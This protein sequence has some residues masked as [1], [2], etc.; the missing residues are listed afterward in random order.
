MVHQG[1]N[2]NFHNLS[3]AVPIGKH[4]RIA[5]LIKIIGKLAQI[6]R[7]RNLRC[8]IHT[9]LYSADHVRQRLFL[10]FRLIIGFLLFSNKKAHTKLLL[11]FPF[12]LMR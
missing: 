1:K 7:L 5:I 2:R 11:S 6:M 4:N 10:L 8:R 9:I 3:A 12:S